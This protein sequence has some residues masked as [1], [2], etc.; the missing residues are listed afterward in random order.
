MS[1]THVQH[2][3]IKISEDDRDEVAKAIQ[4]A[5]SCAKERNRKYAPFKFRDDK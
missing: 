3:S 1:T 5:Y 4:D 2:L